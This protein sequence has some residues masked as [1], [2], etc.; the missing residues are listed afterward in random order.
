M[1]SETFSSL[2]IL[3]LSP[4]TTDWMLY[5]PPNSYV[6]IY[7]FNTMVVAGGAFGRWLGHWSVLNGR[8][9]LIKETPERSLPL[10][11]CDVIAKRWLSVRQESGSHHWVCQQLNLGLEFSHS[12]VSDSMRPHGLQH[13]RLSYP[14]STPRACSNSLSRW[15]H[16][17]ISS[18]VVPFSSCLQS[19]PASGSFF[20]SGGQS[21]GTS[22]SAS[23]V[24]KNIRDWFPLGWTGWISLQSKGVFSNTT[25]QKYQ[26]S[27]TTVQKH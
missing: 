15:C 19:F 2:P 5:A 10:L 18:S 25:V 20:I 12:V 8:S 21:I 23:V 7:S 3:L 1:H 6:A 27:S 22:A 24:P 17:T 9:A 4:G 16:P 26:F 14:S 13:A 11:P